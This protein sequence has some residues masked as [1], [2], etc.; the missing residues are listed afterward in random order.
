MDTG[1][2]VVQEPK[3]EAAGVRFLRAKA[4]ADTLGVDGAAEDQVRPVDG[5]ATFAHGAQRDAGSCGARGKAAMSG[6]RRRQARARPVLARQTSML[7]RGV[8][9]A[10]CQV[11]IQAMIKERLT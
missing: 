11:R 1:N 10:M 9:T 2:R 6:A 3:R 7:P 8:I 5:H 4:R